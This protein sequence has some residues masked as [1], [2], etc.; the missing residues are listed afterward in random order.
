MACL[1]LLSLLVGRVTLRVC[2]FSL[3]H[4]GGVRAYCC[5]RAA[6]GC[7]VYDS[8]IFGA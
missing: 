8:V 6:T 3:Y 7:L 4:M 2:V 1:L 5:E